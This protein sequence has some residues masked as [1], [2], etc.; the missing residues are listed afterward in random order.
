MNFPVSDKFG[1]FC[2]NYTILGRF[3]GNY[4]LSYLNSIILGCIFLCHLTYV[5]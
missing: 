1:K 3:G 2:G 5:G 4:I